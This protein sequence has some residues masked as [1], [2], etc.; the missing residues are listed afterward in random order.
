MS[1]TIDER[2]VEM[3]FDN[4]QFEKNVSTTM[5]TLDKLKQRLNLS[6]ASKG[7]ENVSSAAKRIDLSVLSNAAESV[8]VKFSALEVV[9]V[10]ALANITNSAVN[11]GK[12]MVSAL[13]IDPIKTG[14]QEYETQ[15]N[16]VQTILANTQSKGSTLSDVNKALNELNKYADMTIYNFTEMTRNI[17]TF[18]AAGVDLDKSVTSIKGIANL[19]AVSGSNATQAS[20]AMYQ[21]SQALAAGRVSLMDW[22]SVVNAGMGGE[23]FQ[24][25]LKRTAEHFGYN[26]DG[27]IKKYGS[28]RESLTEG[29][30]L[31]AEVLTETLTQLSGAYTEADLISQGYSKEQAK[32]IAELAQTAVDAATKVKT[33][34]QLWDTLKEAAQSGWTETWEILIGDFEEAKDLLTELSD[35]FG[36][37]IGKSADARNS[38]LYDAMTSN[39]KKITDGITEA[40]LSADEFENKVSEIAKKQG[41]DVEAM[42][43]EYGSL[44]AAF[45]NGAISSN[46]LSQALVGMTGTTTEIKKKVSDLKLTLDGTEATYQKLIKSGMTRAEAQKLVNQSTMDQM[47]SLS[48]LND[49]QLLSI[50]YTAEQIKSIRDLSNN[51]K[52]ANGSLSEFINN[53]SVQNG[54]EMLVDVLRVSIRS[55]IAVFGAVGKAWRD[56]FPPTTS[57][58][59]LGIIKSVRDFALAL[60]PSEDTLDKIHRSFRG[61]F[62]V[63][64]IGKQIIFAVVKAFGSLLGNFSGLGGGIL[65]VT[66]SF[67]DW[68]YNLDQTIK[69]ADIFNNILQSV[70]KVIDT[71]VSSAKRLFGVF[72]K[73]FVFPGVEALL[74]VFNGVSGQMSQVSKAAN[75]MGSGVSNS[76]KSITEAVKSSSLFSLLETLFK[77]VMVL[78]SGAAKVL[79]TFVGS[80]ANSFANTD[81]AGVLD[82][83]NSIISGGVGIAII[84]FLMGLR[85]TFSSVGEAVGNVTGI[86]D[87]VRGCFEAYQN[88]LKAGSLLKIAIAIGILAASILVLSTIDTDKL[89][90]SVAALMLLFVALNTSF[91]KISGMVSGAVKGTF[92]MI[93]F[94]TAILILTSALKKLSDLNFKELTVGLIGVGVLMA[95]MVLVTKAMSKNEK[96]LIK[97]ATQMIIFAAAINIL[98]SA[99]VKLS[100]LNWEQLAKGLVGVGVL[101]A[102]V[103]LFLRTAK[104][105]KRAITSATG[106]VI[107]SSAIL[108]LA[109]ACKSFATMSWEDIGKGLAS[110]GALLLAIARFTRLTANAKHVISTATG[111]VLIG[112]AMKIFASAVKD[113]STMQW[114]EIGRGLTAMA[115]ALAAV[116]LAVRLMPKNMVGIGTGLVIVGGAL[117]ILAHVL[118]KLGGMQWD[119]IAKGL[120]SLGGAIAILAIGLNVMKGTLP[121]AAALVVAA[122]SLAVLT[123]VLMLLGKMSWEGIAKGLVAIAGAFAVIGVAGALLGPIVPSI[124]GLAG[125]LAL[126]GLASVGIGAGLILIGT[127]LASIA[128][129]ITSL[130][131]ALAAGAAGIVS[132]LSLIIVGIAKL[133]PDV[134]RL[135]GEGITVLAEVIADGAPALAKAITSL[136]LSLVDVLVECI[137]AITDGAFLLLIGVMEGLVKYTPKLIDLLFD[138]L[139]ALI[140]GLASRLPDLIK[141]GVNLLMSLFSGIVSALGTI[142]VTTLLQGIAAIG[143]LSALMLALSAVAG[144]VPGAML[145]VLGMGVVIAELALVLAAIGALGQIP[146][147]SWLIGEGGKLLEGIGVAIGSFIGGIVGGIMGGV[148]GQLPGIGSDLSAFMT[149]VT[150][151]I[152]GAKAID[153]KMLDGVKTLA[154][155]LIILTGANLLESLTSWL[156]GGSSLADFGAQLVPFGI[157][158]AAFSASMAGKVDPKLIVAASTAGKAL[159]EMAATIPNSGGIFG[160]FAGEN[161]MDAFA[162]QIV[163]FGEAMNAYSKAVTGINADAVQNSAIAGKALIELANTVPNS[164]GVVSW[165][166]GENDL[167]TFANQLVPFGQAMKDYSMAVMGLDANS[168]TNSTIAG[169]ALVELSDTIPNTGGLISFFTGRN[170]LATFGTQLISF[171][172]SFARYSGYMAVVDPGI[173]TSTTNAAN[174]IVALQ[175]SLPK[176]GGWLSNEQTLSDFG[177]N[178][179]SFGAKFAVYYNKISGINVSQMS[180]ATTQLSRLINVSKGLSSVDTNKVSSFGTALTNLGNAGVKGFIQAFTGSTGKVTQA[181]TGMIT[182]FVNVVESNQYLIKQSAVSIVNTVITTFNSKRALFTT[183]GQSSVT[184]ITSGALSRIPTVVSVFTSISNMA[185]SSVRSAHSLF[186]NAGAYLVEGFANGISANTFK[187]EAQARA[188]AAAAA[189]AARRELDEHSPSR[190]G[191]QIGDFFGLGFVNAIRDSRSSSYKAASEMANSAKSG[192]TEAVSKIKDFV[193]G[194]MDVQ[195]TIRPVLDLSDVQSGASKLNTMFSRN[196]ALSVAGSM[197]NSSFDAANQNGTDTSS[198]G[199]TFSFTQNNYSPKALSRIDIYRQT[200]NQFSAMK[201]LVKNK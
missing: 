126:I 104:F 153:S 37:I 28:F 8:K 49:E 115:G 63:L 92:A 59:L 67:G 76:I 54:R 172:Q 45:K 68:L 152:N 48:E 29:G 169:K 65:D 26:V 100:S 185:V 72:A 86:L 162:T 47:A 4:K 178:I 149:N 83:I 42:V 121:G 106:I 73:K 147:L 111:L 171:G 125:S 27:M 11:A 123:P 159:A 176:E 50:G 97:G 120:V 77:G 18:T 9:A 108:I 122:A 128:V 94:S 34:S 181:A 16:A 56:V 17:G 33:F 79:G 167:T 19:A 32:Q 136:I 96:A 21:L 36:E 105:E 154:E 82:T 3:R 31:T 99:C 95:E 103:S 148:T 188:M 191:Y 90:T 13:T 80:I 190:V 197:P 133:I 186:Y 113:F 132:G 114:D 6:G 12:R 140:D 201:G 20:T 75:D 118:G 196:R 2:V 155:T 30:W 52:L 43:K 192:L 174:S 129:G 189:E 194:D 131:V 25:A 166:T 160:F 41:V 198:S 60:K 138:F 150:P 112:A 137:P 179:A 98:A 151:F 7:L 193:N 84:K 64:D 87:D 53:V 183:A 101:L 23:V 39:W 102:E 200:K 139:I 55:L 134:A 175:K 88:Q 51:Y 61:L 81:F 168:I 182:A 144:L 62:S 66:A 71:V 119:Q 74:S 161:D 127:G 93:G 91:G 124:L 164:G 116:T 5:S 24:T 141:A 187:A 78:V 130:G 44:E 1:K 145:G 199:T 156:T 14:F 89:G 110:V 173:V 170:D 40:G 109:T 38:L 10:T 142:D 15:I 85:D 146:G 57:A 117:E 70:V 184:A 158:M 46:V 163:P 165:F 135:L 35:T 22:N 58:Q 180:V 143:L 157:A 195:P 107:L 69:K 177:T